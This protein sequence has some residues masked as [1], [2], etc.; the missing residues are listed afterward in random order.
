MPSKAA[1]RAIAASEEKSRLKAL[2]EDEKA[3]LLEKASAKAQTE[4]ATTTIWDDKIIKLIS[5][6][7]EKGA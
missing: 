7:E 6:F 3:P 1:L 5:R 4:I 2:T